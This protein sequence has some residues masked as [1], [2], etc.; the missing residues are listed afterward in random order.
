[1][2]Q[3]ITDIKINVVNMGP[4]GADRTQVGPMLAP[5]TLLSGITIRCIENNSLAHLQ[6]SSINVMA[7]VVEHKKKSLY[8][9]HKK[10][11]CQY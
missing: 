3:A 11:Q 8:H 4:A 7:M 5:W 10:T 1:M 6:I 2:T 9:L